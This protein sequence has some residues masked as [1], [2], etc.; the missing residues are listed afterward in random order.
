MTSKRYQYCTFEG[1]HAILDT[2]PHERT[3]I[4]TCRN[5]RRAESIIDALNAVQYNDDAAAAMSDKRSAR[6]A[7][8]F[9]SRWE[10]TTQ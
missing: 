10:A 6:E 1:K 4:A 7:H 5:R 8:D 3:I 2:H 9:E